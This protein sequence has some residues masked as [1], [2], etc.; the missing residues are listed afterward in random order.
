MA[1]S[2][3]CIAAL[4]NSHQNCIPASLHSVTTDT[5]FDCGPC[6]TSTLQVGSG[7]RVMVYHLMVSYRAHYHASGGPLPHAGHNN[8]AERSTYCSHDDP[9]CGVAVW[10]P[11]LCSH[12]PELDVVMLR[13]VVD[14]TSLRDEAAHEG[15]LR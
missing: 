7:M 6:Y 1:D 4:M 2:D 3:V 5:T 9:F 10:E 14:S 8:K 13:G 15:W 12:M 11:H